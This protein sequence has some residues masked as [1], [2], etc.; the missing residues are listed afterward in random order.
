M[1]RLMVLTL[2]ACAAT[3]AHA[4]TPLPST[5][6]YPW[7]PDHKAANSLV[8]RIPPP[9]G[10]RRLA[11]LPG[12]FSEW[13]RH[14]PIQPGQPPVLLFNGQKKPK[15]N[16]YTHVL[17]IDIGKRDLQQ[18]ADAVMRLKAEHLFSA[19]QTDAIHFNFTS[20]DRADYSTWARG[21]RPMI[22]GNQVAWLPRA[23]ADHSY[24]NFR[25]YMNCVFTYAGTASLSKELVKRKPG[26]P[27]VAGDIFI[28]GGFPGHA[29]IVMDTAVKDETYYFV[30]AQ[31][32][33]PAQSIHI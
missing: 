21:K 17:D 6:I 33:M 26:T 29:V 30:L 12:S 8:N 4:Q 7:K 3:Y 11:V 28:R 23:E 20:G 9:P 13:L 22:T 32:Y 5:A 18:C 15:Q 10:A 1:M 25:K 27:I 16:V 31:S 14:I 19:K 24:S 2:A